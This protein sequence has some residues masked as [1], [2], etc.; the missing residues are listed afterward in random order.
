MPSSGRLQQQPPQSAEGWQPPGRVTVQGRRL[1]KAETCRRSSVPPLHP[2]RATT[3]PKGYLLEFLLPSKLCPSFNKKL[4]P[5]RQKTQ[6]DELN[7]RQNQNEIK[8]GMSES[9]DQEFRKKIN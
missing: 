1:P 2:H 3:L 9:P 7:K 8:A 5:E 6:F 4:H